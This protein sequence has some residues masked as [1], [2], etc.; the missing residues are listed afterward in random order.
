[1]TLKDRVKIEWTP[2]YDV[3]EHEVMYTLYYSADNGENWILLVEN[4]IEN[5]WMWDT[6]DVSE[7]SYCILKVVARCSEGIE[8]ELIMGSPV[9]IDNHGP[10]VDFSM[11]IVLKLMHF[12]ILTVEL[13]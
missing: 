11:L 9:L 8:R 5:Y 3:F 4:I 10:P 1:M 12:A 7:D 13:T 2:S 6:R